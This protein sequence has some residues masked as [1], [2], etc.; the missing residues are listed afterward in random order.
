MKLLSLLK[1][2]NSYPGAQWQLD[3][4]SDEATGS[5]TAHACPA[6]TQEGLQRLNKLACHKRAGTSQTS[7][8]RVPYTSSTYAASSASSSRLFQPVQQSSGKSRHPGHTVAH[9]SRSEASA[10]DSEDS[11]VVS[12][13]CS[14]A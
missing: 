3:N 9:T 1:F 10:S 4:F 12:N 14:S 13:S 11:S 8:D 2:R 7:S 6:A 5:T